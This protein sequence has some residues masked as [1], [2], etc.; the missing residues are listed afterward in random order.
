MFSFLMFLT[1]VA[2]TKPLHGSE[3]NKIGDMILDDSQFGNFA[4]LSVRNGISVESYRWPDGE[5]PYKLSSRLNST[6]KREVKKHIGKK[7]AHFLEYIN[8]LFSLVI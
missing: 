7:S 1:L 2:L 4:G 8:L 6:E 5:L 3:P